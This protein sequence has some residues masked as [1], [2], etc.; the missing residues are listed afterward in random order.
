MV[1]DFQTKT[2]ARQKDSLGYDDIYF[3]LLLGPIGAGMQLK[4]WLQNGTL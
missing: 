4:S 3:A 1:I 2:Q